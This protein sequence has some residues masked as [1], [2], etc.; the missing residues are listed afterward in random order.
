MSKATI[1]HGRVTSS[2]GSGVAGMND[3]MNDRIVEARDVAEVICAIAYRDGKTGGVYAAALDIL[4]RRVNLPQRTID[5]AL[6]AG[7]NCGWLRRGSR[8]IELTAAGLYIAKLVLKL[9]T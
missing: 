3:G 9:P 7:E 1:N 5:E 6:L 2:R 8:Q 4:T